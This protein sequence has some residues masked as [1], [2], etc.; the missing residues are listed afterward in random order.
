MII[1]NLIKVIAIIFIIGAYGKGYSQSPYII[2][3]GIAQDAG[4]PQVNCQKECC[5]EAFEN[6]SS[7]KTVSCIALV[8]P[9]SKQQWIFDAT[10]DFTHQ[11]YN[12]QKYSKI[13]SLSGIFI[14]HAHIGHYTGLMYLG[15]EALNSILT[16]VFVMPKM[17]HFLEKNGPWNQLIQ[18]K[19]IEIIGL[20]HQNKYQLNERLSI[21]PFLVPH[22]DEFSETVG[23]KIMCEE[24]SLIFIPDI[25]KWDKW[26]KNLKELIKENDFLLID[27]TFFKDGE[28]NRPIKEVPHPF[29][30]ETMDLLKGLN[31]KEKTKVTFIHF[32]HTN[33]VLKI[34][35]NEFLEVKTKG[36]HVATENQII[37]LK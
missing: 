19:N 18:L 11:N 4:F 29:I 5:K 23:Y 6:K 26:D 17:K 1:H 27:G 13:D 32:N 30:S 2:V 12:L 34:N 24:K 37:E 14:S 22:R 20:E 28:I 8:D 7:S 21:V 36:F 10:P 3:L 16:R 9:K 25:D 35:S 33:P 15:K 31:K